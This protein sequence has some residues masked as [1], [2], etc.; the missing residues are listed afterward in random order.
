MRGGVEHKLGLELRFH[1]LTG[2][3]PNLAR[4]VLRRGNLVEIEFELHGGEA[5][6]M[7]RRVAV[8]VRALLDA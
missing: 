5:G 8:Q 1:G 4:G 3:L 7:L 6:R 2:G